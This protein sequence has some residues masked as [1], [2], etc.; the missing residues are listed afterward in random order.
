MLKNKLKKTILIITSLGLAYV[1]LLLN[2]AAVKN[3]QS[4]AQSCRNLTFDLGICP[5]ER[6]IEA[7]PYRS[8]PWITTSPQRVLENL[9]AI[10]GESTCS[11]WATLRGP[12][13]KV[14]SYSVYGTFPSDYY[15]GLESLIPEVQ[16]VYPGWSVR[17][18]HRLNMSDV[19]VNR[20]LCDLA[21]KYPHLDLC[22]TDYL[23]VLGNISKVTGRAWRFAVMGDPLVDWYMVRDTDSPILQRELD[24]VNMWLSSGT[25]FHVMRDHPYHGVPI[26][27]G[28]WGGCGTWRE[29]EVRSIRDN[30]LKTA[31]TVRADQSGVSNKLW[32]LARKNMTSHDSYTC[33]HFAGS[34][35]Y[36][37]QRHNF[38]YIGE[39]SY[40]KAFKRK[41]L[42]ECPL[43]CRPLDHP[44][45]SY[46]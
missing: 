5:C 46:C 38:T 23:P 43:K 26:M 35:P 10:Y 45:W 12:R 21:C 22:H 44:D 34:Q 11:S 1:G 37:S 33:K 42:K 39:K 27:G 40:M 14:V 8:C 36:P 15:R 19:V 13:Q 28:A 17:V 24:A 30:I 7:P 25:C 20:W 4:E 32:P 9:A 16:R 31:F 6:T 3:H 18:Y 2:E 41:A 29:K